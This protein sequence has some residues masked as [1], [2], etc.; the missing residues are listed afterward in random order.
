MAFRLGI[1]IGGTF[2]DVTVADETDGS[3]QVFKALSTK[4]DPL[5]GIINGIG[6]ASSAMGLSEAEFVS[7]CRRIVHGTTIG[8]NAIIQRNGPVVGLIGNKGFRD[9]LE[10]M[11]GTKPEPFNLRMARPEPLVPRH[12]RLFVGGRIDYQGREVEPLAE[13]D[14]RNVAEVFRKQGVE[15][16]AVALLWSQVNLA[17]EVRVREILNEMLPNVA[18]V[19]SSEILPQLR[20]WDRTSATV[21]S[22]YTLPPIAG[23]FRRLRTY[24]T[25]NGYTSEPLIIQC[26]GG[27]APIDRILQ[28]PG[29][30]IGS[31]PAAAPAAAVHV[32]SEFFS[33]EKINVISIDMGGT[34]FDVGL[35]REG[36]PTLTRELRIEGM[37]L[38]SMAADIISIGAGGGS[39]A[40]VD[41]GGALK[42]GPESAGS[43]P[44]PVCYGLGGTEPTVTDV[45]V[46]LGYVSPDAFVGGQISL[47]REAALAAIS[48]KVAVPLGLDVIDAA[49]GIFK[50]TNFM[51]VKAMAAASVERGVDPRKTVLVAGGGAGGVV[52]GALAEEFGVDRALIP[53]VAGGYSA[54]G[55]TVVDVTFDYTETF[56]ISTETLEIEEINQRFAAMEEQALK[57]LLASGVDTSTVKFQWFYDAAYWGQ[58][59]ELI[60]PLEKGRFADISDLRS[61]FDKEHERI[62]SFMMPDDRVNFF[63][64]RL[65]A[66]V[67]DELE[68]PPAQDGDAN[69]ALPSPRCRRPAWFGG[70]QHEQEIPVFEGRKLRQGQ[71]VPGPAVIEE[72]S[73]SVTVFP[74]HAVRVSRLGYDYRVRGEELLGDDR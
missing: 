9:I 66:I 68:Q 1:D 63:H 42:V 72:P 44:G 19:I 37:P 27:S 15:S 54:F 11:D 64:W 50:L 38:G 53:R 8:T 46:A 39:I 36:M 25:D 59:H 23:Y 3:V 30:S 69:T 67:S 56:A 74:G 70:L 28:V 29:K 7:R 55:M 26:N 18:V 24:L 71:V 5:T 52:V 65:N 2:T 73:T 47:D 62:Y 21:L 10:F 61:A 34:S 13:D 51:M 17:H 35:I 31:G 41:S 57:E 40:S 16:V 20:E 43:K 58:A 6:L 4:D 14:V 60:V 33:R 48:D 32:A 49:A 22:A 45:F 12:R